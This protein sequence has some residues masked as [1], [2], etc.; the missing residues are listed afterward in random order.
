M[1]PQLIAIAG[2]YRTTDTALPDDV[3][4]KPA[5]VRLDG[6]ALVVEPLQNR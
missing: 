3:H 6:D 5:Q 2:T 1:E 4:G